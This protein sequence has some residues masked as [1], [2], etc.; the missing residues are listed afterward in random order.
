MPT[1]SLVSVIVPAYNH[2]KYVQEAIQ[3][4]IDQTYPNIELIVVDD[5]S[6]D[7]TW[8]KI[9]A[10]REACEQRFARVVFETKENQ[11][12]CLTLNRLLELAKGEYIQLLASDDKL[13]TNSTEILYNFLAQHPDYALAV[14]KN[15]IFDD[16]SVVCYWDEN[17]NKV[18]T[19]AEAK[20][21]DF[22]E[23]LS[24]KIDFNS[25]EFGSYEKLLKGNHIPN[26]YLVRKSIFD[27]IGYF[28]PAAPL[29]DY[30]LVLQIAKHAK[31]KYIDQTTFYYR[32]HGA[33]TMTQNERIREFG[34]KTK[35]Y[36]I[37]LVQNSNDPVAKQIVANYLRAR[38]HKVIFKIPA[39]LELYKTRTDDHKQLIL[40]LFS[41][42]FTLNA[43]P[44]K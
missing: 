37:T 34:K 43:K 19:L 4:V 8:I 42:E 7:D 31:M 24:Q 15:E 12:T 6:K 21:K 29:E 30:W 16:N 33:N 32:W 22:T 38:E 28:T 35:Q 10:M 23:F 25:A 14:G 11:G 17:R 40:K 20:Y 39:L 26:G 44:R 1:N 2:G 13:S 18:Y 9:N 27:K 5:G 41:K 36:E 3:S